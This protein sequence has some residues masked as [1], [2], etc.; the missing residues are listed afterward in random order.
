MKNR[1]AVLAAIA[2]FAGIAVAHAEEAAG[3]KLAS[4]LLMKQADKLVFAPCHDRSYAVM[5]DISSNGELTGALN[6]IGLE[7]GK[8]LYV[9]V[10]AVLEGANLKASSLNFARPD[11]RCQPPGNKEEA[12]RAAGKGWAL[13]A[14]GDQVL[15]RR[16]GKPDVAVPYAS[17][18]TEG[19]VSSYEASRAGNK[20]ALRFERGACQDKASDVLV[21]WTATATVNG[22][23]L[24]GCAWQR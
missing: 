16:P 12:W 3:P 10:F 9:E 14:G 11:G 23:T 20:L 2:A 1:I 13:A 6:R 19:A 7:A 15:V 8:K 4:G 21:G 18:K 17:F 24:K 22:E 5:D